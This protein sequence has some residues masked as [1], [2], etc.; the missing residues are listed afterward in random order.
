MI[1]QYA[2]I[3]SKAAPKGWCPNFLL[4]PI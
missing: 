2:S 1:D 3:L 4:I